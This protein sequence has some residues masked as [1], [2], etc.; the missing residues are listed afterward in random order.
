MNAA[1]IKHSNLE[2]TFQNQEDQNNFQ[3]MVLELGIE[4]APQNQLYLLTG[5]MLDIV[6]LIE[7]E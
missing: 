1:K 7:N 6:Q 3:A 2:V 4:D 5:W